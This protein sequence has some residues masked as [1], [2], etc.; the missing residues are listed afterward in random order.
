MCWTT[1]FDGLDLIRG[2]DEE[3]A[4][5]CLDSLIQILRGGL[6][7][8]LLVANG[9]QTADRGEGVQ[10]LVPDRT[11]QKAIFK[12]EDGT[13]IPHFRHIF[14]LELKSIRAIDGIR[15]R[16]LHYVRRTA[17]T[18]KD[19]DLMQLLPTTVI[20]SLVMSMTLHMQTVGVSCNRGS[21]T[22]MAKTA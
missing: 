11:L 14:K 17:A 22:P 1:A 21:T 16:G 13:L 8:R 2:C 18:V 6:R 4:G 5:K 15:D 7:P 12:V 9:R 3:L 19:S 20:L 10:W